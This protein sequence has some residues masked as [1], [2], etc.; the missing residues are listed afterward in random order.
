MQSKQST[1]KTQSN[2]AITSQNLFY[3]K[4][5]RDKLIQAPLSWY[6]LVF[7]FALGLVCQHLFLASFFSLFLLLLFIFLQKKQD[8]R[9]CINYFIF[10]FLFFGLAFLYSFSFY[11][12]ENQEKYYREIQAYKELRFNAHIDKV[13]SLQDKRLRLILSDISTDANKINFEKRAVLYIY[14]EKN[15]LYKDFVF[16]LEGM[17]LSFNARLRPVSFTLNRGISDASLYWKT[18]DIYY[19]SYLDPQKADIVLEGKGDFLAQ[20]RQKLYTSFLELCKNEEGEISQASAIL[21]A[22]IFGEKFYLD[23]ALYQVFIQASLVHSIALSGMHLFIVFLV[24]YTITKIVLYFFP[25]LLHKFPQKFLISF[26]S[27]P[28]AL[29]YLWIGNSPI[30]LIR[31]S[32]M[33]LIFNVFLFM[34]KKFTL[35]DCLMLCIGLILLFIPESLFHLG[36]QFSV[37][38]LMAIALF[39]PFFTYFSKQSFQNYSYANNFAQ[40]TFLMKTRHYF[41]GLFFISFIIQ[42]FLLPLQLSVFGLISPYFILNLLWLP[43][44]QLF[45]LPFAFLSFF[46]LSLPLL[47]EFFYTLSTSITNIFIDFLFFLDNENL[48]KQVQS[49][50]PD[51]WQSIAY[52]LCIVTFLYRKKIPFYSLFLTF[53]CVLLLSAPLYKYFINDKE[54]KLTIHA[55][56]VG[57]GQS[58]LIKYADKKFIIDAGGVFGSRFDTGRDIVSKV[59]TYQDFAHI[60]KAFVSHF[61]LDH[62]KGFYHIFS[63]FSLSNFY[64]SALDNDKIMRKELISLAQKEKISTHPLFAGSKVELIEDKLYFEVLSP[65]E[66]YSYSKAN[67]SN[68]SSLVLRLVYKD[69]GIALFCGDIGLEAIEKILESNLSLQAD[70]LVLPHHGSRDAYSEDFYKRVSPS[71]VLV[72]TGKYNSFHLPSHNVYE[73]FNKNKISFYNTAIDNDYLFLYDLP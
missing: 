25:L 12:P 72:S 13:Q 64:Y 8:L 24:A 31:A 44:L 6:A 11:P 52:Y 70:L 39:G 27:T 20:I 17:R 3:K 10:I 16:P 61:D 56:S 51:I 21:I 36:F 28:L 65:F 26:F 38:S 67:F 62:A 47:S 48:L 49:Y 46:T 54:T 59:L 7:S 50:R 71:K 57:Q 5:E 42:I 37:L 33:L 2:S 45:V 55:L 14:L 23:N 35:L 15:A 34:Y 18:M 4:R 9:N 43:L 60:D 66:D 32:L 41:L 1:Q 73:Y 19:S 69:R 68:N 29:L 22:L 58:I 63:H 40:P 53:S 30:S